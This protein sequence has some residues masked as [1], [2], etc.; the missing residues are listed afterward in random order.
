MQNTWQ[1]IFAKRVMHFCAIRLRK[2]VT[3]EPSVVRDAHIRWKKSLNPD[4]EKQGVSFHSWPV[5][6]FFLLSEESTLLSESSTCR[7]FRQG[8]GK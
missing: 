1:I 6:D 8:L 2:Q 4:S 5:E 3:S 7:L